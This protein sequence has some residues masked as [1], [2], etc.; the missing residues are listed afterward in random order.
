MQQVI[1][2]VIPMYNLERHIEATLNSVIHQDYADLE[3]IAVDDAST[4]DTLAIAEKTLKSSNR[5]YQTIR[6]K[7]NGGVSVARNAGLSKTTGE[8]VLFW[9]G[10]DL[11]DPD[12]IST[13]HKTMLS[14]DNCD[15]AFCGYRTR[16][17]ETGTE[18]IYPA[19]A[20]QI[21]DKTPQQLDAMRITHKVEI[22]LCAM[23]YRRSFLVEHE[24][25]FATGCGAGEDVEFI[26]KAL[27]TCR[28][29]A[30]SSGCS[31]IYMLH[32]LMGSRDKS[33]TREQRLSR[34]EQNT[35]AHRR[36]VDYL[37]KVAIEK[38]LL[39]VL[40]YNLTQ[41]TILRELTV[42]AGKM[43]YNSFIEY[44]NAPAILKKLMSYKLTTGKPEIFA[45]TLL[46]LFYPRLYFNTR[47][48]KFN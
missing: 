30:I 35:K 15:I 39:E 47:K 23:L 12:F 38:E 14:V 5:K 43:D 48:D 4:D 41:E 37:Q 18:K 10:D 7:E 40:N 46:V 33:K 22:L 16:E 21:A 28:R 9:D 11:A 8:F 36:T 1:S 24:L 17:E 6:M 31:Y 32:Q 20:Q 13:L 45:K 3:I 44:V 19:N 2:I 25:L 42:F 29:F 27:A 26:I 34:Y